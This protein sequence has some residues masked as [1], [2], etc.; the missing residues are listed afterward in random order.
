MERRP[1][2]LKATTEILPALR[3]ADITATTVQ[4]L[5]SL[6]DA[7]RGTS[8][9]LPESAMHLPLWRPGVSAT[10]RMVVPP[11]PPPAPVKPV[12]Q[13][14]IGTVAA[15]I[16]DHSARSRFEILRH[17]A[18]SACEEWG[19]DNDDVFRAHL[20]GITED[21]SELDTIAHRAG[22]HAAVARSLGRRMARKEITAGDV[23]AELQA[24]D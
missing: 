18:A 1:R 2:P 5:I 12:E 15:H 8:R 9:T 11:P 7:A 19:T 4:P 24:L 22:F 21:M 23:L 16:V 6:R 14:E 20:A 17:D 10:A 13:T 3:D